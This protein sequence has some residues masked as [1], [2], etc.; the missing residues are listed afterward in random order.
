MFATLLIT[1]EL[2]V[3]VNVY[4]FHPL[5]YGLVWMPYA[6]LDTQINCP[7]L[8]FPDPSPVDS[9]NTTSSTS[10]SL[11]VT[12]TQI[13]VVTRYTLL[14]N[15]ANYSNFS[16]STNSNSSDLIPV[17]NTGYIYGLSPGVLYLLELVSWSGTLNSSAASAKTTGATCTNQSFSSTFLRIVNISHKA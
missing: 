4:W 7:N 1:L 8:Y 2:I 11:N 3:N 15:G 5:V 13:G 9:F 16:H 14:V 17:G 10:Y 12:W 6:F